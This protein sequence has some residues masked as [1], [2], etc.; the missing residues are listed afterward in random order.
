[1]SIA[2]RLASLLTTAGFEDVVEVPMKLPLGTWPRDQHLKEVGLWHREQ[3]LEGL[4]GI[5]LRYLITVEGWNVEEVELFLVEVRRC[6][7]DRRIHCY[8]K[9]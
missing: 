7:K 3:F 8:W 5:I 1:M 9:V 6:I 4:Q 2:P